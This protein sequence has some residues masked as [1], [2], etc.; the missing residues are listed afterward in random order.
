MDIT[1]SRTNGVSGCRN[2]MEAFY[3]QHPGCS[4]RKLSNIKEYSP[5]NIK[6][7]IGKYNYE[8]RQDNGKVEGTLQRGNRKIKIHENEIR[9]HMKYQIYRSANIL[10]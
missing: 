5:K 10:K 6:D 7:Q 9:E 8:R 4:K 2:K 3:R 1:I